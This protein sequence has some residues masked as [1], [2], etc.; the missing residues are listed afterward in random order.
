MKDTNRTCRCEICENTVKYKLSI[1]D[2][3]K[4]EKRICLYCA[5]YETK[6]VKTSV[7]II[8]IL[9]LLI[10]L[11]DFICPSLINEVY[12]LRITSLIVSCFLVF[13]G[14]LYYVIFAFLKIFRRRISFRYKE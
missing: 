14:V 6:A 13:I 11:S 9:G 8:T 4:H 1:K 5:F 2:D 12:M 7:F 10:C 3:N